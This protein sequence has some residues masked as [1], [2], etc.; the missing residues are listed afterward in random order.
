M[1]ELKTSEDFEEFVKKHPICV[2][3]FGAS[4]CGPCQRVKPFF[5][6]LAERYPKAAFAKV[7]VDEDQIS[8]VV[9]ELVGNGIPHFTVLKDAI[10]VDEM[11]GANTK[12]LEAMVER[13]CRK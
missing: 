9:S 5:E 4:W 12:D 13:A 1:L 6:A 7:D 2:I 8:S 11:T 3:D 10:V